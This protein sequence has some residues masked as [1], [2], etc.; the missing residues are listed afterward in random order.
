MLF[1]GLVQNL[2]D[3]KFKWSCVFLLKRFSFHKNVSVIQA[4]DTNDIYEY[5]AYMILY[6][7]PTNCT[8]RNKCALY[9]F[10]GYS[11]ACFGVI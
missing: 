7:F 11:A 10:I 1:F 2:V 5:V 8:D 6:S 4:V 9:H 3:L